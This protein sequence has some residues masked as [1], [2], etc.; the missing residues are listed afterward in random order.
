MIELWLLNMILLS[1]KQRRAGHAG[2]LKPSLVEPFAPSAPL[3]SK[4]PIASERSFTIEES[5]TCKVEL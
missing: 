5:S 2:W 4:K 3:A 1:L